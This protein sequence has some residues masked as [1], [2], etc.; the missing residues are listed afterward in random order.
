MVYNSFYIRE[1]KYSA[2]IDT[3]YMYID[4][5]FVVVFFETYQLFLFKPNGDQYLK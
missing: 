3:T 2:N 1:N 5:V 4:N